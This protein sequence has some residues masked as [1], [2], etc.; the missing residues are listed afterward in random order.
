MGTQFHRWRMRTW[1]LRLHQEELSLAKTLRVRAHVARCPHCAGELA[2]L[3]AT[4][5]LLTIARPSLEPLPPGEARALFHAALE[6]SGV[7]RRRPRALV[8]ALPAV[9]ATVLAAVGGVQLA[10]PL[11]GTH[12]VKEPTQ[13]A[14]AGPP[15]QNFD[16]G[17]EEAA[18]PVAARPVAIRE[19]VQA[20]VRRV[21]R[22]LRRRVVR[23]MAIRRLHRIRRHHPQVKAEQE[24]TV[25]ADTPV[26]SEE[27]GHLLVLVTKAPS[28]PPQTGITV[29]K[30]DAD[31]PGFARASAFHPG[32]YG[33]GTMTE[34]IVASSNLRK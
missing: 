15:E 9:G 23:R 18:D 1:L 11:L 28:T 31:A 26:P 17:R 33:G 19:S 6:S 2:R 10:A 29:R 25:R 12:A 27:P 7:L 30:M 22:K 14:V 3:E 8:W 5:R 34:F 24:L 32:P 4:D 20:V 13:V 21:P 16:F